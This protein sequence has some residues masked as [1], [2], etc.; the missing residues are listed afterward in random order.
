MNDSIFS[1]VSTNTNTTKRTSKPR[2]PK[3]LFALVDEY[4]ICDTAPKKAD[5]VRY[6]GDGDKIV[7]YTLAPVVA[8]A[9]KASAK[10]AR[11]STR[12]GTKQGQ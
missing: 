11:K 7:K 4:G 2:A 12:K 5:L 8:K 1:T 9:K 6:A 10:T 3:T